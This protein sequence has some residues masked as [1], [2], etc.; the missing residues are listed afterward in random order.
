MAKIPKQSFPAFLGQRTYP[1]MRV[2]R[3]LQLKIVVL[4]SPSFLGQ[5]LAFIHQAIFYL[6]LHNV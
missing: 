6:Q 3:I 2:R 5:P 1:S 4:L